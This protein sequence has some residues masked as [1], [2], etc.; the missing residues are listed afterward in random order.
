MTAVQH[1]IINK[2]TGR[3][4]H[5]GSDDVIIDKA[6]GMKTNIK[7]TGKEYQISTWVRKASNGEEQSKYRGRF[8][9]LSTEDDE[10]ETTFPRL[11]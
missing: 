10:E 7:D 4:V 8:Q 11:S 5:A 1:A 3:T 9:A 6:T 2:K